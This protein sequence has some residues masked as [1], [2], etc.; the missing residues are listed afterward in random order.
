MSLNYSKLDSD[1]PNIPS[2]AVPVRRHAH[3]V[4]R[5]SPSAGAA[6]ALAAH[7]QLSRSCW[8]TR[9]WAEKQPQSDKKYQKMPQGQASVKKTSKPSLCYGNTASTQWWMMRHARDSRKSRYD[10]LP[11]MTAFS[12]LYIHACAGR[13]KPSDPKRLSRIWLRCSTSGPE[14]L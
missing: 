2:F 10:L 14:S 13:F 4:P 9:T 8:A 3:S 11:A 1:R 12:T 6:Q 7:G 5:H